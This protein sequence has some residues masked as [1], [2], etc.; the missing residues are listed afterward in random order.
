MAFHAIIVNITVTTYGLL[1]S[2]C[3]LSQCVHFVHMYT[4]SGCVEMTLPGQWFGMG[5]DNLLGFSSLAVL[6][7]NTPAILTILQSE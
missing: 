3:Q 5:Q 2:R 1:Y 7:S 6:G 4:L